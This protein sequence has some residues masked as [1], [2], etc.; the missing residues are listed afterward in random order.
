MK[1]RALIESVR[2]LV[3]VLAWVAVAPPALAQSPAEIVYRV[4]FPEPEHHW[5]EVEVTFRDLGDAPLRVLMSRASPGRYA[6]HEFAK[7]IFAID[8]WDGGGRP[9][10]MART[11]TNAW[12]VA[13]H[14]G[15]VRIVYRIFGDH[16]DGTYMAVD[17]THAHLNAPAAFLWAAGLESRPIRVTF[18]PPDHAAWTVGTQLFPTE[19]P[20]TFTAPGL[21]Y[22]LDSPVELANLIES[23]FVV[24]G[25]AGRFATF[26]LLVHAEATAAD[27]A[28]LAASVQRL[29]QE[30]MAVFDELPDFEPGHYTFLL[31]YLPWVDADAMEHRN[32]TVITSPG[33]SL[34]TP[35]GRAAAFDSISHELFHVWNVERIRPADLE[36]FDFTRANVS[37]CLWMAEGF[38]QYYGPLLLR[39]AGLAAGVPAGS[40]IAATN[41]P[42]RSVR[43]VVG[44]SQQAPFVDAGLANDPDDR[45]RTFISYYTWGA[46]VA[47]GL[48]LTLRER[49]DGRLSLDDY[50]RRLWQQ[51]GATR[52]DVPGTAPTPYTMD[53]LRR[54][55]GEVAGD[56]A[57]ADE[58]FGRYIE[59]REVVDYQRLLALAG[60]DLRLA[61]PG[62]GW[63]GDVVVREGR[64]GLVVG[65][66]G[67]L[68]AFDTPLYAAGIDAGDVIVSI[69]GQSAT[70]AAW[71]A[72][73]R[74]SP[75]ER[76]PLVVARRDGTRVGTTVTIGSDPA[77]RIVPLE[78]TG[79]LTPAQR[80][81]RDNGLGSKAQ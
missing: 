80:A 66:A 47:L 1:G 34:S 60:Y 16:V 18:S 17:T 79:A 13:G 19:D 28:A 53:D 5:M 74:R 52:P 77:L 33:V 39:R 7:N 35:A 72:L 26:R 76:V 69:D 23:S 30:Q 73:T 31:D 24:A 10:A 65:A 20:Y 11:D 68:V 3:L 2:A 55:L 67:A 6:T 81:F 40:A 56:Q 43:S 41:G 59:G 22:F 62:R 14:D 38:T 57:F 29:A 61:A 36:P 54:T 12:D 64:G 58:F 63:V 44:M 71:D 75:G 25:P 32:S 46:A 21:P 37:C 42:G 78:S 9:L 27:V 4:S 49:S 48:D 15:T 70:R 45:S 51:F 50:M 8:A